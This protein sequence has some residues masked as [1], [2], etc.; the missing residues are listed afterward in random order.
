MKVTNNPMKDTIEEQ[1]NKIEGL[2]TQLVAREIAMK[3]LHQDFTRQLTES[4]TKQQSLQQQVVK[5]RRVE[6][7]M[8]TLLNERGDLEKS[9]VR[10]RQALIEKLREKELLEKDLNFHRTELEHRLSEKQ[11]LEE[12]LFEKSRFEQE[13]RNQKEQLQIDLDGIE[14]K[15]Q[16][17]DSE[18]E[19][20][21]INWSDQLNEDDSLNSHEYSNSQNVM[22][23]IN[24]EKRND[25][26]EAVTSK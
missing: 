26:L 18:F 5:S 19:T 4:V 23:Q 9:L 15:L 11:R 8:S 1:A 24:L 7:K 21:R 2:E 22:E 25:P 10:S 3:K 14:K 12:V 17:R 13:L 20:G 16:V 6:G